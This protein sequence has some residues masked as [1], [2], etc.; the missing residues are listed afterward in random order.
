MQYAMLHNICNENGSHK[1]ILTN[2]DHVNEPHTLI[3]LICDHGQ[4]TLMPI[5]LYD[6]LI[7]KMKNEQNKNCYKCRHHRAFH[8]RTAR[9]NLNFTST[10]FSTAIQCYNLKFSLQR[11]LMR[12]HDHCNYWLE[13][14][15]NSMSSFSFSYCISKQTKLQEKKKEKEL[16]DN[17]CNTKET[18]DS[19]E[20]FQNI[21][22]AGGRHIKF[23]KGD[24]VYNYIRHCTNMLLFNDE[25]YYKGKNFELLG[26]KLFDDAL[27]THSDS[28]ETIFI[29]NIPLFHLSSRL[30]VQELQNL[31]KIHG[32][33]IPH[34]IT[35]K[36]ILT[37]FHDHHCNQCEH[38]VSILREN[39]PSLDI[40]S[41]KI[42]KVDTPLTHS[43]KFPPDAPSKDLIETIIRD[44]C[45]E[46]S[47]E[48]LVEGGC[49]VCGQL[50]PI[51]N[52][53]LL[54]EINCD[55]SVI[56]PGNIGRQERFEMSDPV[57]PLKGPILAENCEH[58]CSSCLAFL[59]KRKAPP[60][61]LANHFWIG[62]I[63]AVLQ[64]LT[65]AEKM[66]ISRIRHNKC[67]V[68][69]SSGRAKMTANVIM[70]SNPTVKIYHSLPPRREDVN[71]ILAFIFQGPTKPTDDDIKR[72]PMLVRRNN[73]RDALEWLKLNHI[74][75]EDLHISSENLNDYPLAGVP[76]QID[77]SKSD[78]NSG[79]KLAST[80]SVHDNEIE[81]GTTNGPCPFTVHGLTGPEFEN[82]S[83]ESL[84]AKAL[85]HLSQNGSTLGISH[86]VKPQSMYDNPQAYPQMF[87]WL[88]PYGHGGIGQKTHFGTI[89]EGVHKKNLLMYYDKRF[90]TDLYF[91]MIAFN[92]EQ[93]K[94]GIT[95]SFLL[96]KRQKW[97]DI[98]NRL[99]S[100]NRDVLKSISNKLSNGEKVTPKNSEEKACFDLLNDLDLVG[101]HIK[102]SITSKKHMRNEIWSMISHLGAPSWFITLSPADSRHPISLYYA[103]KNIEFKIDLRTSNE[104]NLL[105]AQNPVAAARFFD[106]MIRMFIKHVLGV[107]S[108]HSGLYGNTSGYYGT[109]EQQGRL[110]LHLHTVLWIQNALSPQEIREKLMNKDSDF[111]RSLIEYLEGC[112]KGEFLTGTL[113]DIKSKV[114]ETASK[115]LTG[116]H[117]I[118]EEKL[119]NEKK[120]NYKDPTQTMPE[121]PPENCDKNC[122]SCQPSK[123]WWNQFQE[124]VD[125]ILLRSNIH[126]CTS[127][128]TNKSK[129]KAKGCLNKNGICKARFPRPIIPKTTVN[130]DDGYVNL[131]KE[132]PML[133]TISPCVTY[134]FRCNTDVTSMLSGTTIKAVISYVT[135]Y[136]SKPIL[137]THQIFS[138][139]YNVFEKN[140]KSEDETL[141]RTNDARKLILKI[142]NALSSKMEIGSPMASMYLLQNP[143]HYTSHKFIPFWWKSFVNDV[144]HCS[145]VENITNPSTNT[146]FIEPNKIKQPS[147]S[148]NEI[149]SFDQ[150]DYEM[151]THQPIFHDS[152]I[153]IDPSTIFIGGGETK[154]NYLYPTEISGLE[155]LEDVDNDDKSD[156][157]ENDNDDDIIN[158]QDDPNDEKIIITQQN[159]EY[160]A[161]SKIDD[162]KYRPAAYK[163]LSLYDWAIMSVKT[164]AKKT[165]DPTYLQFLPGHSQENSHKVKCFG[166]RKKEFILNFIGGTLPRRDYGDFE[167]YCCTMLTLFKPW[168]NGKDLKDINQ[169][170]SD[171]FNL[172]EFKLEEK[173]IL[174]NFNL[175]YECLDE[176]D[177][178]HA[179]L[180]TQSSM[181]EKNLFNSNEMDID[182]DCDFGIDGNFNEDYG[183]PHILGPNALKRAKQMIETENMVKDTGWLDQFENLHPKPNIQPIY[184]S[185]HKTGVEWK[186]IV[187]QCKDKILKLKNIN[188]ANTISTFNIYQQK[189]IQ[190][191]NVK[192]LPAKYFLHD[193]QTQ[194]IEDQK[195]IVDTIEEFSLNKEQKRAFHII[196]NHA[197][198]ICPDQLKMHLGGMGGTGKTQVIKALISMFN[199]RQESH[200]FVVL[201]PTGTAAALLNGSTY[202]SMLGIYSSNINREHDGSLRNEAVVIKEVQDRLEGVDY[203][204]IDEISMIACHELYAI[205]SQLSKVTNEHNK[206]FG[207]KNIILAGDFAQLPP[208][209]GSPLYTNIVSKIQKSTMS[210]RDQES[211]IGKILWHQI[212]TVVILTQN[213]RQ[214]NVS[215]NDMKFR[216]ALSNM[217]YSACT[218][219][220][221]DFL[222][223]LIINKN[224][225]KNKLSEPE[226]RNVSIIT[227]LNTQKDQLNDLGSARFAMD[228]GQ[229][230]THFFSIDKRGAATTICKKKRTATTKKVAASGDIP[231]E[232]QKTLWECNPHSSEHFPGK[233]SLCLGMPVM[234]R[235]NDATE[236]CITKGQEAYVVGWDAIQGPQNQNVLETLYL[237]L[238]NPA[239]N[240]QLPHLPENTI[241]MSRCSKSIKCS[242]PNDYELNIIRQQ[243]NI[244]P[245]FSM[246]DYASQGK[247]RPYNVVN[248][249][250]CR[251]FQ[252]IYTCLSRSSSAA[253]TIILQGFKSNKI[254]QGLSGHLRQ[255]FRELNLLNDITMKIYEGHINPSYFGTLRNPMIYKYQNDFPI[256]KETS[257]WHNALKYSTNESIIIKYE[258]DCTWNLNT[259]NTLLSTK[260][261]A[262]SNHLIQTQS[263]QVI[264][265]PKGLI[266]NSIDYSCAYDTLFTIFYHIWYE[267]QVTHKDYFNNGPQYLQDLISYFPSLSS[268]LYSFESVHDKLRLNLNKNK[269]EQYCFGKVYTD[270]NE[271]IVDFTTKK[272]TGTSK[273]QCLK[274]QFTV[275]KPYS[276]FQS[277]TTVGWSG[278]DYET[279]HHTASIQQY[280]NFKILKY[281][282]K[283]DKFCPKCL[284]SIHKEIPLYTTQ[285]INTLPSILIFSLAPWIDIDNTLV[286]NVSGLLK[287]YILKAIIYTNGHHFT[288][289]LIDKNYTTW[290]YDGQFTSSLC[291]KQESLMQ[292]NKKNE[293]KIYN[294]K[295]LSHFTRRYLINLIIDMAY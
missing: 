238:I 159:N 121:A 101:G 90:Q 82:I 23:V 8:S 21:F 287:H 193:F 170:W 20:E 226:F 206:P 213:M 158:L 253:G 152:Q 74:D 252:S 71:E 178:Y 225:H 105:V 221:I 127:A 184:P 9:H 162:Y 145:Q 251:N 260:S 267:N 68:R 237:K 204:F 5:L 292:L 169:K 14:H 102:G 174:N 164:S 249:S 245:N 275:H 155:E 236:L 291:R 133:N 179:I 110:T 288:A 57:L 277:Y 139:A 136:I 246:T 148:L 69:V 108:N 18:L 113:E 143:D 36:T 67:L 1:L 112:Q 128:D 77:Y 230:L 276:Y 183:D 185:V 244:L 45:K 188:Y 65:F 210:K 7:I 114:P 53:A 38:Y 95:S 140:S 261:I 285:Y 47:P 73:V 119:N 81:E 247:T 49:A 97:P 123:T 135:D 270:L 165:N 257:N 138:T 115:H 66:L 228:T 44:F 239:K 80:M 116:I 262:S 87:P 25:Q 293:L 52:M 223:T 202:H 272:T 294:T 109:V 15:L 59:N 219:D 17:S 231:M 163:N 207:G 42:N 167:Y 258:N 32:L 243:I 200:R 280:L 205:S 195:I 264:Q 190:P 117:T 126:K 98:A 154:E 241:P 37:Y 186:N 235:N 92:H 211:A 254:T 83:L 234:I 232:I 229:T 144:R 240:I 3:Q 61:S 35:K 157:D 216:T 172:Y 281:N 142:V 31:G 160:I 201:A 150:R 118:L 78:P 180:K 51:K 199:K 129:F 289:R 72:T 40:K 62:P 96:A 88:F 63:P 233:L 4:N 106:L 104:R 16:P 259:Y 107:G 177:D 166:S 284:K 86:D 273:L 182:E 278:S 76:V 156:I 134:L 282:E 227:S 176:R 194:K 91:P 70:F 85:Q 290:Y 266:W 30:N 100:L 131:K 2:H 217:R 94:S 248:L 191:F 43:V 274:C 175:R 215:D 141:P 56:S 26:Y 120:E 89:S 222:K 19:I 50:N 255:E 220:D 147:S 171:A 208:T 189:L 196:A 295:Q 122:D 187:K 214:T 161:S 132:E 6:K 79:N 13:Q 265:S 168:R 209:T 54:N 34:H 279:L 84:K 203:I 41:R 283:T 93:L 28:D 29:C 192:I 75:Y 124:T 263:K 12:K 250:H 197:S 198:D 125:D 103:D 111:Q 48:N 10:L 256:N 269:P 24:I 64:N 55:L 60:E 218:V 58:V 11:N 99:K 181:N 33:S 271:L 212:T 173:K 242:L 149:N 268:N 137:K 130:E 153:N 22:R 27:K 39:V 146:N 286:F 151:N 46:T 224:Q